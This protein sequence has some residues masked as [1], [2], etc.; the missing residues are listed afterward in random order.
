MSLDKSIGGLRELIAAM[1][2][3]T[4]A[5]CDQSA[6][7]VRDL[8]AADGIQV[9]V[10]TARA[11]LVGIFVSQAF[12]AQSMVAHGATLGAVQLEHDL[13]LAERPEGGS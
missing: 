6:A 10:D 1:P 8:L 3:A 4:Q 11:F 7:L 2:A 12:A 9:S 5:G 13:T